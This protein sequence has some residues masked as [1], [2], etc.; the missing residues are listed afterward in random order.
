[1]SLPQ[2]NA[3]PDPSPG[4]SM[5]ER[6]RRSVW[7]RALAGVVAI[8]TWLAPLQVSLQQARQAAG[9]LAAGAADPASLAAQSGAVRQSLLRWAV[10]HLPVTVSFGSA[11]AHA[12][13]ITDPNAPV[14]F[15]PSITT[16][17]GPGAPEGGVPV[18]GITTPN[19]AGISLNQYRS[20]VVDPIGLILNNSTTGGGTFLGGQ[21]GANASLVT[22]GPAALIIN[23]V[24]SQ[25]PA[26]ING[27]IEVFGAPAGVVVAAPGG[28]Y[29]NG[30]SFTNTTQVTLTTGVP[31]FLSAAGT[32][33]SF[34][35]ATAAGFLVQ[36]GR[37]QIA[38]PSPGNPNG[39]GI[40]GTVGD[41]NL[42]AE[43]IGVDAAL[44]AG[45][46]INLVAGRQMV[47]PSVTPSDGGFATTATGANNAAS[48]T[49]A[50]NGLAIDAT[51]FGAMTAGQI[52]IVST[53]AGL[54]VRA[55]G[56]LAASASN[57]T[58]D[59]AGN[60][61]VGN[62][63]AKQAG[64]LNA[65]GSVMASGNG[66]SE[67]GYT[68]SAAQDATL[69]G[70]LSA[71]KAVTVSA[72]GSIN[73]AGGVQAQNAVNLAAGGSVDV[74]GAVSGAQIAISATGNDG[75]GDI[76]LGGDVA[77][78]GT[79]RF[80]AARDTTIDGSAVSAADLDLSTRRN[81]AINGMAGSTGGNVSLA[82]VT[83]SV[84]TTGNVVSPGTLAVSAG[85]DANLGGQVLATGPVNVTARS[86]SI[87]TS[88]QI[89]SNADLTLAAAQN[90]TVGGQ[91]QSAGK[92][93]ITA[94]AGSAAINGAL[95]S[96]GDAA[97]SAGQNANVAGSLA[98]GG[99]TTVQAAAGSAA[100]SGALSSVGNAIVNAGQNV[101]LGGSV[102][103]GGNLSATAGQR[104]HAGQLTW[105]GGNATLRG[106]DIQLGSTA[107]Q[108]NAVNG[109]LDAV[110]TRGLALTGDTTATN[111]TLGG[112]SIANSGA[113][114]AA[115]QL[116]VNGGTVTNTGTLA[117]NQV[118]VNAADLVNRGTV[119]GQT[120]NVTAA[121]SLD[122]AQGLIAG[123]E[124]LTVTTGALASNQGGTLFAGDL[125]G[126]APT[127]GDLTLSV[128]GGNG[129]F[130]NAAGQIL[131]GNNLTVNTP[132]Q[133]FDPSAA[134]TGTL[135][136]NATLT[137]VAQAVNNTGM[138]N[139]PGGSVVLGAS[140]GITN[141][142]TI[143]KAGDLALATG[144]TLTNSG[145][146]VGGGNLS[147]SAGTLT[148]S[149]TVHA[150]GD[151]ALAG[152]VANSGTAEA[153][154]NLTVTGGDYDNR[155]GTTQ[156]GGDI[157]VDLSGTLNNIGSVIGANGNLH[158][159]AGSVI[160]DRTAPV[161]AGSSTTK[162]V[163]DSLLNSTIIGSYSPWLPGGSCDS[164][165]AYVPG[166]R[167]NIT[168]ADV[169]RNPDGTVLLVLGAEV[170]PSN[171]D[172]QLA[173]ALWHLIPGTL[174]RNS[175]PPFL[176]I[177]DHIR[178]IGGIPTVDHTVVRQVDGTA[179]QIIGRGN[180]D[181]TTASLSNKGGV[182]SAGRDVTLN[183]G[184]LDNSR[185][186]TLINSEGYSVNQGELSAFMA[187]LTA[188]TRDNGGVYGAGPLVYGTPPSMSACDSCTA[189]PPW[190]PVALGQTATGAT[191]IAPN[192]STVSHQLG[193]AGQITAGGN[194]SLTGTGDL[195][196]AGD[197]AAA[198][199]IAIKTPGTFTN[200]GLHDS[201][202]TTT[203]GC[204]AGAPDC[205]D[206]SNPRVDTLAWQQTPSTVAAGQTLT[207][208][209]ANIQN[210]NATLAA[211][212]DVS[213]HA[214]NSVTNRAGAIQSLAGDVSITAPTLVN[215]TMDPVRLHKS[216][217]G[218]NPPYAGGC[219]PAGTY[220]N[221]Q[222][223]ADEDSAAGP[224]GVISAARDVQL[225]GT[226]LTNKGALIT[227]GRNVTVGMAGAIDNTSLPLNADWVGRWQEDR[228][229]GD[230][231]HDTAGRATLGS[232]ESGI[233]AGNTLSV[234][235]GGQVLNTGNLMGNTVD[236]TGAALV[237]GYTS[238][239]QPTPPATGAQQVISLGP[240]VTPGGAVPV[241]T[242]VNNPTTPWQFNPVIVA[243]PSAPTTGS[244]PSVAWHFNAN[245]GG[246][247]VTVPTGTTDRAQ[248]LN[249]SPA[250]AVLAGV[251]PDSLLAQL[252]A[253]LRPGNVSFYY[254]P[255]TEG[256]KLQQAALQQ[257]GQ[258][259]FINGLA[260][261]SQ[262]QLSV[263]DLE[264]LS[265]YKNAA[266]YAKAHNIALGTALTQTQINELDRPLLWYV[267]QAVPDPNCNT[268][269][270]T[271]CP[272]VNALVPQVY[273]PEGYA[274]ALT[275]PTGGM[276][277]GQEVTLDIA[278]QLR[279]SGVITAGDTLNVKAGSIDA[280]PN[281]VD[282]GTS[283]YKAQGGWNV[284]TGTVV[285]PGGF[286]SA[287]H[288]NIEADSI[289]AINDAFLVRG[290]DGTVDE[291]ATVALVNQLKANLGL[292][293][294]E[295]TVADD[296]HTQFI[297]EKKGFGP[298]GQ[299]VMIVA[300]VALAV[301]TAGAAAAAL[302]AAQ[303]AAAEAGMAT[304]IATGSIAEATAAGG[305]LASSAFAAGGMANL[306][307]A[308]A[309]GS[310]ASSAAIQLGVTGTIKLDQLA[311]AGIAGAVTG[312]L[313]GYFGSSYGVDRLLASGVAGCGTAAMQGGDCKSGAMTGFATAAVAWAADAMRQD[314]IES[315]QRFKGV[316]DTRDEDGRLVSNATG[317]SSGINGDGMKIAG[318]RVSA[319]DLRKYGTVVERPD[320]AW[321][322]TG[323]GI[324]PDTNDKWTL[325]EALNK[326]GGL[327]G[328]FQGLPGTLAKSPYPPGT[329]TDKVLESFA[330]PHDYLG[331]LTAYDSLGNLK[332]GMTSFQRMMFEIQT[333]IDIPLA[334]PF[335]G[336]TLLNQYGIDWSVFRNQSQQSKDAK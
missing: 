287:M 307:I 270:S 284:I 309:L 119:G 88:G 293:Y 269:A 328:G 140:Q 272:T 40:E 217:G 59:A 316:Y 26:R 127:V 261:D 160:N 56:N 185:S 75:R 145:Q 12:A 212:G 153:L 169:T 308:G 254:D 6:G 198:G 312:G 150:N 42:I 154:G 331:S 281:V 268:V 79:I 246:N 195:T 178:N 62:T 203:P 243:T 247:P 325:P 205:P 138:W 263:T 32:S 257:T 105:V 37:V 180:L 283:A 274:Q 177:P 250:T 216:Y 36:G 96:D 141:S 142:G 155:G 235:A 323:T 202:I 108:A 161:D 259:S 20:F 46:Q 219:N 78:P 173:Q 129:S 162:V 273:L 324:N 211:Q 208:S 115:R 99:N 234:T 30:A 72:G 174:G 239:A 226:T 222:C 110:A 80:N 248:Y 98:S 118:S 221:S 245:L 302:T 44:Y 146:I 232:L 164:C 204:V 128:T 123:T 25:T 280:A 252:P 311:T 10:A 156:A 48:N 19:A 137:L 301:V 135:N 134:T 38:N 70:T 197:L 43:S 95:T 278:G 199:K 265:L 292:N 61:K 152:N 27:T 237:N 77:S 200:Q 109:T 303:V 290:A 49:T 214:T 253:E 300:A 166:A 94:A 130:N 147:L 65:A 295:G 220:G 189:P 60:L 171:G 163:N 41:I 133:V 34:D 313:A 182:I 104:M 5:A 4:I 11:A 315:S 244:S 85:T 260:W 304:L 55:D 126:W 83:G 317:P 120:A 7:V 87:T 264:K 144:G 124:A 50:A 326:E 213:L 333:D 29:T 73:G 45:N 16:T 262:N 122:N 207:V 86:G 296:I 168:L 68:V 112:Q 13:P 298:L 327:T 233:Q 305:I 193:K 231:W 97:I 183:V 17:I 238:P 236:L 230:R 209:A 39:V 336:V 256:Q 100:V 329:F 52:R 9:A 179:G 106:T 69:G 229:G 191:A 8:T 101:T 76:H 335:A 151:L 187:Q 67:A 102:L 3:Q 186:A 314:Q 63:Y 22:S 306:A 92:T 157:K 249:N 277:A 240:V 225:S 113:T 54:G 158:I 91:A 28:V 332:E 18:V 84:T 21:V 188:L 196:N 266:D 47:T 289:R 267:Q 74:G 291:A 125:A 165:S 322:F 66:Q 285:Q 24:T 288:M 286:M 294:T 121:N 136:A 170:I 224:A 114:L 297:K 107:T 81:L 167:T 71:G 334:A 255:Y 33:T 143:Q 184:S 241:A 131:A 218:Q 111:V 103:T 57:L 89:G 139:V 320:G 149:G 23:Q 310:I 82:G 31:Q 53:A 206:D 14:R 258:A 35:A 159:A 276:I 181:I 117:G 201:K 190:S 90:V 132:N 271:A 299:I 1:M 192:Q 93:T 275:K 176:L 228:S 51:A 251:T 58:L 194:L 15:T 116:T 175:V 319:D 210:L 148:N 242:P 318:T 215:A 172:Q 2:D 282:I 330:G 223:A 279:N 321:D 64:A 227:G